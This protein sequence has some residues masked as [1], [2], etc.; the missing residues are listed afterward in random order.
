MAVPF[1]EPARG[2]ARKSSRSS[3][4]KSMFLT[5]HIL[6]HTNYSENF[7]WQSLL[8]CLI[9]HNEQPNLLSLTSDHK[10]IRFVWWCYDTYL[11]GKDRG[12]SE[13]PVTET[14]GYT[15]ETFP[16]KARHAVCRLLQYCWNISR[17]L[18]LINIILHTKDKLAK[19][20]SWCFEFLFWQCFFLR[21]K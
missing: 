3:N 11:S 21:R 9:Q 18:A 6:W 20:K 5:P 8:S 17:H 13:L 12:A 1:R 10:K 14:E 4:S 7:P 2:R 16:L 15:S 19:N